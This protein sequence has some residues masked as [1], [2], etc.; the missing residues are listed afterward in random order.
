M[1]PVTQPRNTNISHCQPL[2]IYIKSHLAEN[3]FFRIKTL[4]STSLKNQK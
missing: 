3:N 4:K 1:E 2:S